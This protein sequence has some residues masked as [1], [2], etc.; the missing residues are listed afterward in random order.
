MNGE[1]INHANVNPPKRNLPLNG[2]IGY[3]GRNPKLP[4]AN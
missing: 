4:Q 2:E 3:H 1:S